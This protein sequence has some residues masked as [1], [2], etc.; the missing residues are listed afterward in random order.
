[1]EVLKVV[2]MDK[3]AVLPKRS[4]PTDSGLDVCFHSLKK[5]YKH[6]G[7]NGEWL[8]EDNDGLKRML[9]GDTI[10]LPYLHRALIG[11]GIKATVGPGYEIQ[12]RPRSG[13]ALKKGITVLNTPGTIDEAY[14]DE[15]CVILINQSRKDQTISFGERI[16][17]LVVAPILLT[18]VEEVTSLDGNDRQGGFGSTGE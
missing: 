4:N 13:L 12:V 8:I 14:R 9:E 1:M 6:N 16:A 10:T 3:D 11:T 17:Q 18:E 2:R 7:G 15:I 5:V